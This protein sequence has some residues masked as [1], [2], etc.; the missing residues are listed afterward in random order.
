MEMVSELGIKGRVTYK[1][2]QHKTY[3]II[4]GW[5]K[6]RIHLQ[7]TRYLNTHPEIVRLGLAKVSITE[8]CKTGFKTS[9]MVYSGIKAMEG[10][11]IYLEGD[12]LELS[13]FSKIGI[14]IPKLAINTFATAATG[15]AVVAA[16]FSAAIGAGIVLV[17]GFTTGLL[18]EHYDQKI[19]L[20]E[21][22]SEA[23]ETMWKNLKD[24]WN[25]HLQEKT[26]TINQ[27]LLEGLAFN[28][29]SKELLRVIRKE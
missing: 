7:G 24:I 14:D 3:V 25:N 8:L 12:D 26:P 16:G 22:F 5:A 29:S 9:I 4:K 13:F 21:K 17:A 1:T 6:E 10:L 11:Q 15:G 19:G 28:K 20:T 23:V 2:V 18:L 27:N